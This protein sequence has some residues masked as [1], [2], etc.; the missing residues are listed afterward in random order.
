MEEEE[1]PRSSLRR[2]PRAHVDDGGQT[3]VEDL[4]DDIRQD[5]DSQGKPKERARR[6][7]SPGH[8]PKSGVQRSL[9]KLGMVNSPD[10]MTVQTTLEEFMEQYVDGKELGLDEEDVRNQLAARYGMG[11]REF[12]QMLYTG[13]P[14]RSSAKGRRALPSF[15]RS[16]GSSWLQTRRKAQ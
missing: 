14:R 13:K 2:R 12:T 1:K 8:T 9:A 16:G 3:D 10:R 7:A 6:R 11:L 15:W 5:D 4:L